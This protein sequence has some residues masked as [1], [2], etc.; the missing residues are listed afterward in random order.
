MKITQA[1]GIALAAVANLIGAFWGVGGK[2]NET[3]RAGVS[4]QGVVARFGPG[5]VT[6]AIDK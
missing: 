1:F 2:F 5:T 3:P 6:S 4:R